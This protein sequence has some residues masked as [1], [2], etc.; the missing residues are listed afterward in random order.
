MRPEY[1][2]RTMSRA[3]KLEGKGQNNTSYEVMFTDGSVYLTEPNSIAVMP[4]EFNYWNATWIEV[5]FALRSGRIYR[6][7]KVET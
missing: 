1:I 4:G 2:V 7:R 5:A 3:I 6:I